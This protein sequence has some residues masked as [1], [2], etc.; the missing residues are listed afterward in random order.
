[1]IEG[2][3]KGHL[4]SS[5][6]R[7]CLIVWG[8]GHWLGIKMRPSFRFILL[9]LMHIC[10]LK[11]SLYSS[12]ATFFFDGSGIISTAKR[13]LFQVTF[14]QCKKDKEIKISYEQLV[15]VC[16][17]VVTNRIQSN[18]YN[19]YVEGQDRLIFPNL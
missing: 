5:S 9:K 7:F 4:T 2:E 11:I 18:E 16:C 12:I 13:V 14:V 17:I 19:I 3:T 1:M 10:F 6:D 15:K 8:Q